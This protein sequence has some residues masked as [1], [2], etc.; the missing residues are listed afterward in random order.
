[1]NW[2]LLLRWIH[3]L[4]AITAV[5][6]NLTYAVWQVRGQG[7]VAEMR[8]ALRGIKFIDDRIA[9]PTY[10]VIFVTGLLMAI[11]YIG[12][13]HVWVLLGIGLFVVLAGVGGAAY[14]PLLRRQLTALDGGGI[15]STAYKAADARATGVGIFLAVVAIAIV[16]VMVFKPQ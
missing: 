4:G 16:F 10:G 9:N 11:F 14:T 5:G 3:I 2:F 15:E 13:V 7:S 6:S 8:F 12:F 1:M